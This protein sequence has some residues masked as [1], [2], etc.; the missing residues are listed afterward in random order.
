M[1]WIRFQDILLAESLFPVHV[2]LQG[3][4]Y[5]HRAVGILIEFQDRNQDSRG[6]D[7]GVVE[8]V[9]KEVLLGSAL[10]A[11]VHPAGLEFIKSAR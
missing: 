7:D 3:L 10:V 6:G 8:C 5:I 1:N 2:W 11:K 4:G 9:A